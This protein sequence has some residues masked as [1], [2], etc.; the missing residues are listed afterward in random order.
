M[1]LHHLRLSVILLPLLLLL[2]GCSKTSLVNSWHDDQYQGAKLN[3]V[4]VIGML[5]KEVNR[6]FF[7]A[8]FVDRVKARH[9]SGVPSFRY[10]EHVGDIDSKD[11]LYKA[12]EESGV[13]SV[14]IV[15][16]TSKKEEDHHTQGY[17]TWQP[18]MYP[19]YWGYYHQAYTARYVP[20]HN[21][22]NREVR[23][24]SRVYAVET[25]KLVWAGHSQTFNP[26]SVARVVKQLSKLIIKDMRKAGLIN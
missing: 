12:V 24:E 2:S 9:G 18:V 10:I 22:V 1:H 19:G 15:S 4:M 25:G 17:F 14:L 20:G 6:R 16:V 11:K 7:E 13:D 3:K 21:L 5:E 26:T 8:E 23:L